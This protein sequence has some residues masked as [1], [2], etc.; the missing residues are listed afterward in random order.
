MKFGEC[1]DDGTK[2][3]FGSDGREQYCTFGTAI[4]WAYRPVA[5]GLY[6]L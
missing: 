4:R 3:N 6:P 5:V 2:K 1:T